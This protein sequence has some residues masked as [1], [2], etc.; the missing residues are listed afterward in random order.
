M[1]QDRI[2]VAEAHRLV[3]SGK[4]KLVCAYEDEGKCEEFRLEGAISLKDLQARET[5]MLASTPIVF[6]CA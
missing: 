4:A 1:L 6:Y 2:D 5:L 3:T